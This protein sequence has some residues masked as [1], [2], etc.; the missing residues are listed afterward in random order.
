[1]IKVLAP[2]TQ[3][4]PFEVTMQTNH[5]EHELKY[6]VNLPEF[7]IW[8]QPRITRGQIRTQIIRQWYL[9]DKLANNG[10]IRIRETLSRTSIPEHTVLTIKV[11]TS[12]PS[13][14][15]EFDFTAHS[16][17]DIGLFVKTLG[18]ENNCVVKDRWDITQALPPGN[19]SEVIVDFFGSDDIGTV[20]MLEIENPPRNWIPPAWADK[21]VTNDMSYTNYAR[22][23]DPNRS[24]M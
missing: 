21:N 12:D 11:P 23:I 5:I 13:V 10:I 4:L 19:G 9:P 22:A 3:P 24:K 7:L 17:F 6:T 15:S 8:A 1:M 18:I 16:S 14:R 20:A 2:T